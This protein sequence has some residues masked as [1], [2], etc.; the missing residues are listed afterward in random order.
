[1]NVL[2]E[3]NN[4]SD[5]DELRFFV[6]E[7]SDTVRN[8][9]VMSRLGDT[10]AHRYSVFA[11]IERALNDI[12]NDP[13]EYLEFGLNYDGHSYMIKQGTTNVGEFNLLA[14]TVEPQMMLKYMA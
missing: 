8:E 14:L 4:L 7:S 13:K 3:N 1:M 9:V 12:G 6:L 11:A 5:S 10:L 2:K